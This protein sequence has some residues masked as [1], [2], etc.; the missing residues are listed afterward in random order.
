[1]ATTIKL[2]GKT[3]TFKGRTQKQIE[4]Y[5]EGAGASTNVIT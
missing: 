1:M 5:W 2:K 3:Y 4:E